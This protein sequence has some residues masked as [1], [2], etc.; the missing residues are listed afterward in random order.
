MNNILELEIRRK[1]YNLI[2]RNPGINLSTIAEILHVSPQ[3]VDYH[4]LYMQYH[5]LIT[6][7]KEKGYK[8]CYVKDKV[9]MED[10]RLLAVLRQN[11]PLQIVLFLLKNPYS[12]HRDMLK[13]FGI[14]SPHFSYY[15]RKLVKNKIVIQS[16]SDDKT[17]YI[18]DNARDIIVLLVRYKPSHVTEMVKDTWVD[19]APG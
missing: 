6:I 12:R 7:S 19:F 8:R 18:V 4:L 9:G 2:L 5:H 3:L 16:T 13:H 15:L 14:S 11:I 1:I 10:K 17:G